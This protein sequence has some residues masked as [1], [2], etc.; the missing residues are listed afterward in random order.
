MEVEWLYPNKIIHPSPLVLFQNQGLCSQDSHF[1]FKAAKELL[2]QLKWGTSH[3]HSVIIKIHL[4]LCPLLNKEVQLTKV[5]QFLIIV[6]PNILKAALIKLL[7]N[8]K[9]HKVSLLKIL[10][11]RTPSH[12]LVVH[13]P[14]HS[15]NNNSNSNDDFTL[16]KYNIYHIKYDVCPYILKSLKNYSLL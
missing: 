4:H 5:P 13:P 15:S 8:I 2:L 6:S 11:E 14:N 7:L 3:H 10:G 16:N 12:G 1:N 9:D